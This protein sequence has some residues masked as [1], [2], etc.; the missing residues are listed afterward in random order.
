MDKIFGFVALRRPSQE[1]PRPATLADSSDFQQQLG[2]AAAGANALADVTAAARR[3]AD[4]GGM[5]TDADAAHRGRAFLEMYER[6]AGRSGEELGDLTDEVRGVAGESRPADWAADATRARDTVLAA[7]LL[8]QDARAAT[9]VKLLRAYN[10][11]EAVLTGGDVES[12]Q[13]VLHAPFL[14]P[15]SLLALRASP[16][17]EMQAP[18]SP[19]EIATAL[20]AQFQSVRERHA[21]LSQA[22]VEIGSH[23]EDELV[24][25]ELGERR[26]L[27]SLYEAPPRA[28]SAE[29]GLH[30]HGETAQARKPAAPSVS[31]GSSPLRRAAARANVTLSETGVR[32][33]SEP[34]RKALR[35][36]DLDPAV[37][38]VQ[39]M[40]RR[41]TSAHE[42]A[43]QE[44]RTVA[45]ELSRLIS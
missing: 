6:L 5:L 22:L 45:I 23:D 3:F 25:D 11:A 10:V 40:Q 29:R 30:L 33:L 12:A 31:A 37:A 18:K 1:A 7:Y 9:A 2:R 8:E 15:D 35:G 4:S 43:T 27:T 44:L 26:P 41:V 34:A 21:S 24:L 42:D 13:A 20:L 32:L 28:R 39:E 17:A 19:D 38:T 36:L 16:A 14:L